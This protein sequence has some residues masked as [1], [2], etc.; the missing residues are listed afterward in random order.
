MSD[1]GS[2]LAAAR[3]R[4]LAGPLLTFY[5]DGTGERTELSAATLSNWVAKTANLL[6]DDLDVAVGEP[7]TVLLP[8]HWQTAVVLLALWSIGAAPT[9]EHLGGLLVVDEKRIGAALR[10]PARE[11]LGLSL[12]P[13]NARL[14]QAPPGVVDYAAEVL[15][16]GDVLVG[17]EPS[18]QA[19]AGLAGV[20]AA[21]L[22]LV[23]GDRV[24]VTDATGLADATDW[25]LAPL[26][27]GASV[28][29][30]RHADA[31]LLPGRAAQER[32]TF[33]LGRTVPGLR[34]P[35]R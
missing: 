34:R 22:G 20:R 32:V 7:A 27:A 18:G 10:T 17:A 5:D 11:V 4:D 26:S 30:C 12:R 13:F 29:L 19:E 3:R 35:P 21:E 6:R 31:E 33:T 2:L 16:A 25:L 14:A 9:A 23:A 1:P 28:V 15:A 8:A 24:L